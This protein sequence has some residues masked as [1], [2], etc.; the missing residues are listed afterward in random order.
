MQSIPQNPSFAI[1]FLHKW[2]KKRI[3][4][5]GFYFGRAAALY[6]IWSYMEGYYAAS[7]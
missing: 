3:I 4:G 1:F 6:S 5:L 2:Q 7:K